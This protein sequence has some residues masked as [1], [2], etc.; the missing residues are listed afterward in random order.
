MD[1]EPL[2]NDILQAHSFSHRLYTRCLFLHSSKLTPTTASMT[3]TYV[4]PKTDVIITHLPLS[5]PLCAN[6]TCLVF[7]EAGEASQALISWMSQ[8]KY[9]W[10][11]LYYW[12]LILGIFILVGS[13]RRLHYFHTS[14]SMVYCVDDKP[15]T[16]EKLLLGL[17]LQI[18]ILG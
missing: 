10:Y 18:Q 7:A 3:I 8:L 1:P 15:K 9:G 4:W 13:A 11:T 12:G 5:N 16:G 17:S 2:L 6:G 14:R